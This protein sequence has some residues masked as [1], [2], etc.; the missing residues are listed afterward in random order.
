MF[1]RDFQIDAF[2][3]HISSRATV[4]F[5]DALVATSLSINGAVERA[6]VYLLQPSLVMRW[7]QLRC[8][9]TVL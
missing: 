5:G 4:I 3:T 1:R 2:M 9:S 6:F 8:R 7:W